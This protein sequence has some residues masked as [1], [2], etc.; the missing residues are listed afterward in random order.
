MHLYQVHN[1][2]HPYLFSSLH[3]HTQSTQL[4]DIQYFRDTSFTTMIHSLP[5]WCVLYH[6]ILVIHLA[7]QLYSQ[8]HIEISYTYY[9]STFSVSVI[10]PLLLTSQFNILM[11]LPQRWPLEPSVFIQLSEFS[12]IALACSALLGSRLKLF[13]VPLFSFYCTLHCKYIDSIFVFSSNILSAKVGD[14]V[15]I[16]IKLYTL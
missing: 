2:W 16:T 9:I 10:H 6:N 8:C 7:L 5:Q 1:A 15:V 4:L 14:P 13:P 11:W 12:G 3:R